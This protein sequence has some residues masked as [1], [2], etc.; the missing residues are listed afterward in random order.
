VAVRMRLEL[1]LPSSERRYDI[2][3][4][5]WLDRNHDCSLITAPF[6]LFPWIGSQ[7][8]CIRKIQ[9]RQSLLQGPFVFLGIPPMIIRAI[10]WKKTLERV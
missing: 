1:S 8:G 6:S 4:V 2:H 9:C 10:L 3:K 7:L 5:V